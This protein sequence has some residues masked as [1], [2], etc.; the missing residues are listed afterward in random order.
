MKHF[1]PK[2]LLCQ[3]SSLFVLLCASL[4]LFIS[5]NPVFS[6]TN[7]SDD[8]LAKISFIQNLNA[9]IPTD[10]SF[11]DETGQIVQL[12][13]YF[14]KKPVVLVLGYYECP[15][16]CTLVL[17]GLVESMQDLR[18][19]IGKEYEV[20][21][22]SIDPNEK[23]ALAAAKKRT[24]LKRYGRDGAANGWHFLTGD[25][26][27]IEKISQTVGFQYAYDVTS[28]QYA[29]PSG[30]V[31]LTPDGRV[32]KYFFGVTFSARELYAGLQAASTRS[33]GSRI[34]E[35]VL[36]C[37]HYRPITSKYGAAIMFSV[38]GLAIATMAGLAFL[39]FKACRS[40]P[41]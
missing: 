20:V 9:Q 26:P 34:Q 15:M 7:I 37:F 1:C 13:N 29:H 19:S 31:V 10:L 36:L 21:N 40:R 17:N 16:L 33:I 18:W 4:W 8:T 11:R 25:A 35:L 38:R 27:A 24:Y 39:V 22:I 30:F 5:E 41:A 23:P 14:G 28:K 32:S 2:S 12:K 6:Q 3:D